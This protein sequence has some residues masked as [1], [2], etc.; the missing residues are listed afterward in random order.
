M[1]ARCE[2]EGTSP[3]EYVVTRCESIGTNLIEIEWSNFHG[4]QSNNVSLVQSS[5]LATPFSANELAR[6][7]ASRLLSSVWS[8]SLL[9]PLL[10][11]WLHEDGSQREGETLV[12]CPAL[13]K[14]IEDYKTFLRDFQRLM[15]PA[16]FAQVGGIATIDRQLIMI[17]ALVSTA[18]A[19]LQQSYNAHTLAHYLSV[20]FLMVRDNR[21]TTDAR[22]VAIE[23]DYQRRGG[24]GLNRRH[25]VVLFTTGNLYEHISGKELSSAWEG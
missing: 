1:A 19:E 11:S 20:V 22:I 23:A 18:Q 25:N 24:T 12:E 17:D 15:G 7:W 8:E 10:T 6:A 3:K 14:K 2:D 13:E 5:C 9:L 16:W 4:K 21:L